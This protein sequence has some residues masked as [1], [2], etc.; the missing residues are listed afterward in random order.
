MYLISHCETIN[1]KSI[2]N[3]GEYHVIFHVAVYLKTL[4]ANNT[5]SNEGQMGDSV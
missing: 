2:I 4:M 5:L 3:F 1:E